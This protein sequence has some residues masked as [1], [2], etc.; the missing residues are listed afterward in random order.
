MDRFIASFSLVLLNG[1]LLFAQ[2]DLLPSIGIGILPTDDDAI[3][4]LPVQTPPI[5]SVGRPAGE[6]A[7]DFDL[8]DLDGNG[9]TLSEALTLGKP[10]LMISASYTCPV[11]R[12]KV[13]VINSVVATYGDQITTII[14]YTPEAHPDIDP[15]PYFGAVNTGAQNIAAGILYRQPTTY[16]E[17]KA[18]LQEMLLDLQVDAP[19]YLDGPCNEWWNYYG[20]Q[21]NNAYLIATDGTIYAHHDWFDRSPDDIECDIDNL[22]G[23]P[24]NCTQTF[25]G[26]FALELISNDTVFGQGGTTIYTHAR[27]F[28]TGNEDAQVMVWKMQE[29]LPTGW[30]SS[31]C[32][33]V[34]YLPNVDTAVVV[35][36][37]GGDMHFYYYFYPTP[38][39]AMGFA[40]VGLRNQTT[41]SNGFQHRYWAFADAN[42][43]TAEIPVVTKP[44]LSPNPVRDQLT[45]TSSEPYDEVRI[46]D[47]AGRVVLRSRRSSTIDVSRLASGMYDVVLMSEGR[48]TARARAIRE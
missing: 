27:L 42:V 1:G 25:G 40:H 34:C 33:D 48:I 17:R 9:L 36:P 19:I 28:N 44:I 24:T 5:A 37:A 14:V 31:L 23:T 30:S 39:I 8:Y 11:F 45:I 18:V 6:M 13:P 43:G 46:H 7:A 26:T 10:V 47:S 32:L 16:G 3:C 35:V 4:T 21:P 2:P 29:S 15:S 38:G 22:L 20:P 41:T 12:G